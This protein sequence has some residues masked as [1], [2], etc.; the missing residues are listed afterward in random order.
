MAWGKYVRI[1]HFIFVSYLFHTFPVVAN[2]G[3]MDF[4]TIV[5]VG[6]I[7]VNIPFVAKGQVQGVVK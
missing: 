7:R 3:R 4:Y 2:A 1:M 5:N 6:N